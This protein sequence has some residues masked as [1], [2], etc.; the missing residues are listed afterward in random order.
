M[1]FIMKFEARG[2]IP[3]ALMP[4]TPDL[5]MDLSGL[6]QHLLDIAGVPG[7]SALCVNGHASE[8]SSCTEDEQAEILATTCETVG[9][10]LPIVSGVCSESSLMAADLARRWEDAG[11]SAL[12]VFPPSVFGKGAQLRPEMVLEHYRRIAGASSLPLIIFQYPLGGGQGYALDTLMRLIEEVPAIAGIKDYCGD[13]VLH[14]EVVRQLR[15]RPHKVAMLSS[16]SSWLL[17]SLALGC[18][19]ILSGA[20]ST[21]AS[22]QVELFDAMRNG[23][24]L[25]AREINERMNVI[26][27]VFYRPPFIDQHNRMKEAQVLLGRFKCAAVRP[28]IMKL[29]EQEISSIRTALITAGMLKESTID[30]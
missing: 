13:P 28:P 8:V 18:D 11:A 6:R 12:L 15:N 5:G 19:G 16:H 7:V 29:K 30:V 10:K 24:L 2:I 27:R 14:E 26:T 4:W 20:G 1:E 3:A 9:D 25:L 22:L 17:Q 21:I 23:D